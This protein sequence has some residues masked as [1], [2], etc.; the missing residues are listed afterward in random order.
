MWGELGTSDDHIVPHPCKENKEQFP[1]LG[2]KGKKQRQELIGFSSKTNSR[3]IYDNQRIEENNL[4]YMSKKVQMPEKD[5][6]SD[7][8]DGVFPASCDSNTIKEVVNAACHD[9]VT[10]TP[11]LKSSYMNKFC[12]DDPLLDGSSSAVDDSLYS[13]PLNHISQTDN[14]LSFLCNDR[15]DKESSD[16]LFSGWPDIGSFEDVDRMFR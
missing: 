14:D 10:S 15:E 4:P 1:T 7:T 11:G 12:V 6:W 8:P 3:T 16:L 5:S 2:D 13:H 9:N